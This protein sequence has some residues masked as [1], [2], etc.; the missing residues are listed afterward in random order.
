M[1]YQESVS[2]WCGPGRFAFAMG[3]D[4]EQFEG[5]RG[6]GRHRHHGR[7]PGFAGPGFGGPGWGGP[8]RRRRGDVRTALLLLLNEEPRNGYQLMQAIEERSGGLWRPSPGSVYP[9]LSQLEDEGLIR[10]T[11]Q[12]GS[13]LFELTDAGREHLA[14]R[15]D[16]RAPWEQAEGS[17]EEAIQELRSLGKQLLLALRQ[18][19]HAGDE[20]QIEKARQ[21]LAEARRALYR[22]L[23][24]EGE[25]GAE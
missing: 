17:G 9:T 16:A 20:G 18:V 7:G 14:G 10:A 19:V 1:T 12:D 3:E 13:K 2:R 25:E 5:R 21:T 6:R 15:G 8:G 24:D 11:E 22:I 4:P 23:A